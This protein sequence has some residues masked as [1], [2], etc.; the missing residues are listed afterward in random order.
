MKY[1]ILIFFFLLTL[2]SQLKAQYYFYNGEYYEADVTFE[3]GGSIGAM[4]AFT[5]LG[6]QEGC[7]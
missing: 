7:G 3:V 6:W 4:N 2:G 5:D 1:K